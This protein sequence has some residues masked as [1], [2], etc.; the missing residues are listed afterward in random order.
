M[1]LTNKTSYSRSQLTGKRG[2]SKELQAS[3]FWVPATHLP[4]AHSDRTAR[5]PLGG[6]LRNQQG[7]LYAAPSNR[8]LLQP[9]SVPPTDALRIP[10]CRRSARGPMSPSGSLKERLW[11]DI[12]VSLLTE[13][14]DPFI[15]R[16]Y[17]DTELC[18]E[19]LHAPTHDGA[20]P[21]F[22]TIESLRSKQGDPTLAPFPVH[23]LHAAGKHRLSQQPHVLP[24]SGA[25]LFLLLR[26][27][28]YNNKS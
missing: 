25:S 20:L 3:G 8:H 17:T 27:L 22:P 18:H 11:S 19:P 24:T 28:I 6:P 5:V 26:R 4:G 2:I 14:M 16:F 21:F 10:L 12:S 7:P 1:S 23:T 13:R 15:L 9:A